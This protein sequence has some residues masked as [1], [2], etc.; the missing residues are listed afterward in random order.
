MTDERADGSR[1]R[2][3]F[4]GSGGFGVP[5]LRTLAGHPSV[6]LVGV[7]TAR[8]RAAGRRGTLTGTPIHDTAADVDVDAILTPTRLRSPEAIAEVLGLRPGLVVLADYG[9][10]VPLALLEPPH[11]ASNL[12]PSLLPRHR[13]ATPIPAAILAG[14]AETGVSLMLMD[15]GLDTGPIVAAE[16][17]DLDGSEVAPELEDRLAS[18]GAGLLSRTLDPWLAGRLTPRPQSSD[19]A[20]LTRQLR[21]QD[22][23]LEPT[24]SARRTGAAGPRVPALAGIVRRHRARAAGRLARRPATG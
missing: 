23:R 22:G 10:I 4:I 15:E 13:G 1:A 2:T 3:V 24:R 14:D 6:E 21:R 20:T 8:P 16:R 11:G 7:V 9:Q 12:H 19:G 18:L 17:I 5:T